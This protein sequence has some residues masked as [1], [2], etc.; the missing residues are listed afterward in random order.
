MNNIS[1]FEGFE[2]ELTFK[3]TEEVYD[4]FQKCSMDMN[5]L[6]TDLNFAKNK[7][8]KSVVMYG[9]IL[10]AFLSYVIGMGLPT[11]EVIL[12]TQ[13]IQYKNPVYLD[14]ELMMNIRVTELHE[15]FKVVQLKFLFKNQ[16]GIIVAKGNVQIGVFE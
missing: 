11:K 8:F 2:T 3:V 5:P 13:D 1:L 4:S 12:Q 10:N 14:D 6:H 15:E 7:G 9:N 16:N